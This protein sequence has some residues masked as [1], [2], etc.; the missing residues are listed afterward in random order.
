MKTTTLAAALILAPLLS[1]GQEAP[2]PTDWGPSSIERTTERGDRPN[3]LTENEF[4]DHM[5]EA[6]ETIEGA[7]AVDIDRFC[8]KV[9][10]GEGRSALGA[11]SGHGHC[12]TCSKPFL[13]LLC[14]RPLIL[15]RR[16]VR[17]L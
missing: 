7:C 14:H 8:G 13:A 12:C 11:A 17:R 15:R 5:W 16:N 10:L 2:R 3:N 1:W 9:T 6:I 4:R